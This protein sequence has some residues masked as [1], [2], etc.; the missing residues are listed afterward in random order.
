MAR[1]TAPAD[2]PCFTCDIV[3]EY[4]R[5]AG[6]FTQDLSELLVG[7]MWTVFLSMTGLW[8]S[9][10]GIKLML[11]Q[12]DLAA[13]SKE[14]V[15]V[16]LAGGLLGGQGPGLVTTTYQA[17][18][19]VMGSGASV[20]MAVGSDAADPSGLSGMTELVRT[21][22]QGIFQVFGMT[23]NILETL[24]FDNLM[25]VFYAPLLFLPYLLLLLVFFAQVVVSIFR[26]MM[27][28]ALS[29]ILM[30]CVGFPWGRAMA[31][32]GLRTLFSA[33][34]VLFGCTI[35][36][37]ICLYGVR[38]LGVGDPA[39]GANL[40]QFLSLTNPKLLM[41]IALGWLGTAFMAEATSIANSITGSQLTNQAATIITAGATATGLSLL[42]KGMK[43][44]QAAARGVMGGIDAGRYG[45]GVARDPK[46]AAS[47]AAEKIKER[48]SVPT[49][50]K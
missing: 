4:V 19:S 38:G 7:P 41:T 3:A 6:D 32:T 34:M 17:A 50:D 22:E 10:H 45:I 31:F 35:A 28:S 24:A 43:S 26:V 5:L 48:L 29:P 18:L 47:V 33:F 37:G 40:E 42:K 14:M 12:G 2:T 25:P 46:G 49:F 11:G 1:V 21:A 16:I 15:F 13:F 23:T 9:V 36:M 20:A 39:I 30:M 8:I 27:V 44:P